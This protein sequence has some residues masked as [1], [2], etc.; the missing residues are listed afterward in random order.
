MVSGR[1]GERIEMMGSYKS[2]YALTVG[3]SCIFS[4]APSSPLSILKFHSCVTRSTSARLGTLANQRK[5]CRCEL[6]P[7]WLELVAVPDVD[8][9]ELVLQNGDELGHSTVGVLGGDVRVLIEI[10]GTDAI[11]VAVGGVGRGSGSGH[12]VVWRS[13]HC[14]SPAKR[15]AKMEGRPDGTAE[16][17]G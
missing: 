9:V 15:V 8:D 4:R 17:R 14:R 11:R 16:F 12:V 2:R 5:A 1:A 3:S 6:T 7:S 10:L 13:D